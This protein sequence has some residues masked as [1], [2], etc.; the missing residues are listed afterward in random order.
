MREWE[1][2]VHGD[3][4][5]ISSGV[6]LSKIFPGKVWFSRPIHLLG[7]LRKFKGKNLIIADISI[8]HIHKDKIVKEME[9]I[10]SSGRLLY[11]DHHP[12]PK[13]IK[14]PCEVYRDENRSTSE[15][16]YSYFGRKLPREYVRFALYGAI[17]DYADETN[18]VKDELE[19]WDKRI[20]YFQSGV[21]SQGLGESRHKYNFKRDLIEKF[22]KGREPSEITRLVHLA[23]KESRHNKELYEY[24]KKNSRK[25]G[26]VAYILVEKG[27]LG[28][29]AHFAL[30]INKGK[31]GVCGKD[32][33][34]NIDMSI[35]ASKHTPL[36]LNK[37]VHKVA[38]SLGGSGGGH[39][40]AAGASVPKEKFDRFIELLGKEL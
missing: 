31:I 5:G 9:E 12:L 6:L 33:G 28:K 21:L 19:K 10:C 17:G 14:L 18:W 4:D 1:I 13:G 26:K 11:F 37:T 38:E 23:I 29:G 2:I 25:T 36:D 32:D 40:A 30:G 7:D 34:K 20:I 22:V 35:R 3:S 8:P 15:I 39:K 24:V 16:V 27:S